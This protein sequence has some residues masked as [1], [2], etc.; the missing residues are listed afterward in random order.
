VLC[1]TDDEVNLSI[2]MAHIHLLRLHAFSLLTY[3]EDIVCDVVIVWRIRS[4]AYGPIFLVGLSH[5]C[6]KNI[7]TTPKQLLI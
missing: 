7:L 2:V 5:F 3:L 6:P 1:V 4:T